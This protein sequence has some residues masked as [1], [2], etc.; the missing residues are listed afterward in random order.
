M[1]ACGFPSGVDQIQVMAE[2]QIAEAG[3]HEELMADRGTYVEP[4]TLQAAAYIRNEAGDPPAP[5]EPSESA[6]ST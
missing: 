2:G 1:Q 5:V 3:T 6:R 4:F